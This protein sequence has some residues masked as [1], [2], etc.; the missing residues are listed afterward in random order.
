MSTF[1]FAETSTHI[2]IASMI[3]LNEVCEKVFRGR[4]LFAGGAGD[5]FTLTTLHDY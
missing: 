3:A 4:S 1:C 5:D 2:I